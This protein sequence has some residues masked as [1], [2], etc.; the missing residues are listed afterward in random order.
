MAELAGI[1]QYKTV[2]PKFVRSAK[3]EADAMKTL[4]LTK[5]YIESRGGVN[6]SGFYGDS[7]S[8]SKNLTP[9]EYDAVIKGALARGLTGAQVGGA[10]N[11]ATAAKESGGTVNVQTGQWS[12]GTRS[13]GGGGGGNVP[14]GSKTM[15]YTASDGR[16]FTDA[17]AYN[18]YQATLDKKQE[19]RKS[20]YDLLYQQFAQYGLQ[21]LVAP[22]EGLIKEAVPTSEFTIR[23]RDTDAYKKRFAANAQRIA[24]GYRALSEADYIAQEDLYQDV[25][26][27]FGMPASYYQRGEM[28]RQDS[29]EKLMAN[30]IR[31][32]ELADRLSVGYDQV[33]NANP[34][35][36]QAIKDFNVT[37]GDILA[38]VLDPERAIGEIK[39]KVAIA[40]IGAG[41]AQAGLST[42]A[43]R[44]E[45]LQRLGI[46]KAGAREGF[47]AISSFLPQTQV[48]GERY[49]KQGFGPY[50]QQTAEAEVFG[51]QGSSEA[52]RKRLKLSELEAAQ[53]SGQTGL[54]QGALARERAGQF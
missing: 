40:E 32:D 50:T 35:V 15:T 21:S 51:T 29:F 17:N 6:A 16:T 22:L 4:G 36:Y 33:I 39:R 30:N 41:A 9:E 24:K 23:L 42:T 45:E 46:T 25:M 12:G 3:A 49:A 18:S 1:G 44:A 27:K 34:E 38:Y 54:S 2:D 26:R 31:E 13:A 11:D 20:A 37:N 19:D 8:S 7:W 48:L 43:A 52:Q 28:G 47:Q 14:S 53:F 5:E 10:L